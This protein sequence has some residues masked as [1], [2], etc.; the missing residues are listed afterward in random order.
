MSLQ[1]IHHSQAI[2]ICYI[3]N[4]SE[5]VLVDGKI[6]FKKPVKHSGSSDS[7]L[8]ISSKKKDSEE[9]KKNRKDRGKQ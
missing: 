1:C 5:K 4:V 7:E 3:I 2:H 6:I 8:S 9:A